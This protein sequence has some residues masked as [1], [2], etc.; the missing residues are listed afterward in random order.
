MKKAAIL[1]ERQAALIDAPVPQ[2]KENWVVVKVHAAPMCAEYKGFVAGH[3][4]EFLGHEAAGEVVAVAQ[5]G[6]VKVGDRVVAMP[7]YSCGK[8]ALCLAGDFIHCQNAPDMATFLGSPEGSATYAQYL[9]KPDWLLPLIP[10]SV[11]YERASLAC[12]GLGPSF[13]AL[14]AMGVD[15]FDTVLITGLGPVGLGAVVNAR[16]RGARV[17]GVESVPYR[18]ER[19]LEMG[20]EAVVDPRDGD[21]LRKIMDLT[22]GKGVDCALD[23]AGNPKAERLGIDATRRKGQVAYVGECG[24]ELTIR[25]S[26]DLIRKGLKVMGSWHYNL[27]DYPAVM[28]VIQQSPLIDLLIS[29]VLPMSHIQE[30]FELSAS[31]QTAKVILHPWE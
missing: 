12:C 3:R 1:G 28:Q 17:I 15:A 13:G 5:P 8:C 19:A 14:Q 31:H 4:S 9:I 30:A 27:N 6:K 22:G 20:A 10:D 21:A 25:V 23:C 24:D 2:P 29:H 7:L 16:F 26:P 11:S 18:V